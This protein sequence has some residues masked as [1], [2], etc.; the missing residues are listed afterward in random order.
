MINVTIVKDGDKEKKLRV[1]NE[2][3]SIVQ[4]ETSLF[5]KNVISKGRPDRLTL[6]FGNGCSTRACVDVVAVKEED[7]S[8]RVRIL[9]LVNRRA[10]Y[11]NSST[12]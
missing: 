6:N 3:K 12:S 1:T 7:V 5:F 9:E 10:G 4:S 11:V 8:C 2:Q